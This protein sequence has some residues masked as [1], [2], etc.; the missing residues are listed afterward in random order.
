MPVST[1]KNVLTIPLCFIAI[2]SASANTLKPSS[3]LEYQQTTNTRIV[4][5][6]NYLRFFTGGS[7]RMTIDANGNVGIGNTN[8]QTHLQV[9][10]ENRTGVRIGGPSSSSGA[11]ADIAFRTSD[12]VFVGGT[13]YWNI[14]YRCDSW[15]GFVGDLVLYS[16]NESTYTSPFIAQTDGD[17]IL[18]SGNGSSR[19]GK[20]GV[21]TISPEYDLDVIGTI[22]C[23]YLRVNQTNGSN[24]GGEIKLDGASTFNDWRIDNYAGS[25]RLHHSG[26]TKFQ[27]YPN[28]NVSIGTYSSTHKLN[29]NGNINASKYFASGVQVWPDYVFEDAYQLNKLDQVEKYIEE[30][31]HLPEIPSASEVAANGIDLVDMQAKLLQKI[32]ELTLY[33]IEQNK[34]LEKQNKR[35]D[36]QQKEIEILK[37]KKANRK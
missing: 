25:Y 13:N 20:V 15:S 6:E 1:I 37:N 4:V 30:N 33:V 35:I 22:Q 2:L 23:D 8:P 31:H 26:S 29:V 24:E 28:G 12:D 27:V 7:E 9:T 10:S 3:A 11:I 17:V 34:Q 16:K 36:S 19:N 32:E 18:V 14:S 21:G 5:E